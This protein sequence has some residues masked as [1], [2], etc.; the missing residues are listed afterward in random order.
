M[1]AIRPILK[2]SLLGISLGALCLPSASNAAVLVTTA[3]SASGS[4]PAFSTTDL[5]QTQ[6]LSS[7]GTGGNDAAEHA[8]LFNGAIGNTDTDT[9][10]S[11]EVTLTSTNSIT[12]NFDISVN[13][14]GYDITGIE[15]IMGWNPNAGGRS[16]QGYS[17]V[18]GFVGGGSAT[19]F[20]A[21]HWEPN[22]P[23]SYWTK[24]SFANSGGG[25]LFNDTIS[26][27]GGSASTGTGILA[28]G[29]QSITFNIS[30]DA[31]ATSGGV[32]VAREFDVFGVATIPEPS[33]FAL[34]GLG[35]LGL[36]ARRRRP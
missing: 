34:L 3:K 35:V 23:S 8:Q 10:D 26:L 20:S 13:T 25:T 7:S 24:V 17:V 27:N 36:I 30:Q 9:T 18:L 14:L 31:A 22:S 5:A 33:S 16:N 29:V 28:T 15:T 11:G 12:V 32:V 21:T 19:L 6:Y 1:K 4:P 2:T